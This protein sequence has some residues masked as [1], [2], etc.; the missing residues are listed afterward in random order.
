MAMR[1][2]APD[3][4]QY[5]LKIRKGDTLIY[6]IDLQLRSVGSTVLECCSTC[7]DFHDGFGF[8]TYWAS[9]SKLPAHTM[10]KQ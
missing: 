7:S 1:Q 6:P 8:A 10:E 3:I 2:V 4:A 9:Q 5:L